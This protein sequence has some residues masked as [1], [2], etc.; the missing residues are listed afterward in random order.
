MLDPKFIRENR[1]IV[2]EAFKKRGED[3]GLLDKIIE[4]EGER[5]DLLRAVEE[6][7]QQRNTITQEIGRLKKEG[8]DASEQLA[9]EKRFLKKQQRK[10]LPSVSLK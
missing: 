9:Q 3:P 6:D 8:K 10:R 1:E 4:I 2:F 5:R 7:R